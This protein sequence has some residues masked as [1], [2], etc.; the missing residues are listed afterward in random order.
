MTPTPTTISSL[1]NPLVKRL[2]RLSQHKYRVAEG[3][4][5]VEGLRSVLTALE[6]GARVEQLIY[7]DEL[8]TSAVARAA[9]DAAPYPRIAVSAAVFRA[10]SERDDPVGLGAVVHTPQRGLDALPARHDGLY[11]ALDAVADPGNLGTIARTLDSAG[12]HGLILAGEG[13]DPYHPTAIK[14][15]LGAVFALPVV[16]APDV[17]TVLAWA[18]A[19][20]VTTVAT[21]AKAALSYWEAS[22][23]SPCLLLMGSEREGLPADVQ[24]A[25][26]V[27]VTIPMWGVSSSLNLAVATALV[28]YEIRRQHGQ[29]AAQ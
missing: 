29:E 15:S 17:A 5:W 18:T 26:D 16:Q 28:L 24:A 19:H 2:R 25:T 23:A 6:Q 4:C 3:V 1:H 14:A 9:L 11:V 21:S 20:K 7:C 10:L 13:T 22:Y 27:C 12:A 8:L